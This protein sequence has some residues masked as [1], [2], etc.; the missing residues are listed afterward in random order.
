MDEL[1]QLAGPDATSLGMDGGTVLAV[2]EITNW[3]K[4]D[5]KKIGLDAVLGRFYP[6]IPFVVAF[7]FGL[8]QGSGFAGAASYAV[9]IGLWSNFAW[10][11]FKTGR[12]L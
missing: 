9:K 8:L 7:G 1:I 4:D 11:Q 3:L 2:T 6:V 10:A 5:M 12:G